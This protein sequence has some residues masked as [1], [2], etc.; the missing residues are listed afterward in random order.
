VPRLDIEER[1]DKTVAQFEEEEGGP[2]GCFWAPGIVVHPTGIFSRGD[3]FILIF[4]NGAAERQPIYGWSTKKSAFISR[5]YVQYTRWCHIRMYL[6]GDWFSPTCDKPHTDRVRFRI[7]Y[8]PGE[9]ETS[10]PAD[11]VVRGFVLRVLR[12]AHAASGV[13]PG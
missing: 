9:L 2:N 4:Q 1:W 7:F 11:P 8:L 10:S 5:L 3:S 6:S 12:A 13:G